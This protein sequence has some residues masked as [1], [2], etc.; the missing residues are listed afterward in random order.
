MKRFLVAAVLLSL[1]SVN[2]APFFCLRFDHYGSENAKLSVVNTSA[3]KTLQPRNYAV[4]PRRP[5]GQ[6]Q[7]IMNIP[8]PAEGKGTVTVELKLE[9]FGKTT[10]F[11][12]KSF[13]RGKGY[14]DV[15]SLTINGKE[16]VKAGQVLTCS[17]SWHQDVRLRKPN[18]GTIKIVCVFANATEENANAAKAAEAQKRARRRK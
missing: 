8:I 10:T 17:S 5:K 1:L 18:T 16:M 13:L 15:S 4:R 2:A 14:A 11:A 7:R 3:G 9:G 6:E 12:V